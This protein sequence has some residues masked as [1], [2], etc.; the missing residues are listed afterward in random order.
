M[1]TARSAATG[2]RRARRRAAPR[3]SL[4]DAA[5]EA[6]RRRILDNVYP[7]GYQ[8]LEQALATELGISRTPVREALIRLQKE[9]LVDVIPRHGMR[10]LSVSPTDMKEIYEILSA[11]ES[12]AAELLAMRKPSDAELAP[13]ESASRDMA[14]AL[15]ADDL[16]A[17]AEADERFHR[18]LIELAGNRLLAQSVLNFWDR[19]HRVRR[20]TLRLRPKPVNSTKEHMALVERIRAGDPDG[21]HE[22]NRAHRERAS[23]ELLAILERYRLQHL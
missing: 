4:V 17:W 23:R 16:D 3:G 7:P 13:L 22:V 20:L 12:M 9:G 21:A 2:A 1:R 5:Y 15:R 18:Q 11:L 19:A 8:A 14:R 10:V 6:L